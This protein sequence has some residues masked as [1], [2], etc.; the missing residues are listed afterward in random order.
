M[1]V[2]KSNN[3][4]AVLSP[5]FRDVLLL[6][7]NHANQQFLK[8]KTSSNDPLP[9][10]IIEENL[11][12]LLPKLCEL[13]NLSLSCGSIDGEKIAHITPLMK[14]LSLDSSC[15]KNYRPI[16]NLSIVSKLI[17]RVI[18]RRLNKH[19]ADNMLNEPLQSAFKIFIAVKLYLSGLL[20]IS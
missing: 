13:V 11:Q 3:N 1:T 16:S 18:L 17:E 20:M 5:R 6:I 9:A 19:L 4:V 12:E 7:L 10:L 2:L 15:L 14:N 8:I